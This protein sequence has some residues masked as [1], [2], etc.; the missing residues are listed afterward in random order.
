MRTF[1]IRLLLLPLPLLLASCSPERVPVKIPIVYN[2]TNTVDVTAETLAA[3]RKDPWIQIGARTPLIGLTSV[4]PSGV[5]GLAFYQMD[6]Y[7]FEIGLKESTVIVAINGVPVENI[8]EARKKA[9]ENRARQENV[10]RPYYQYKDLMAYLFV[11][12]KW[13]EFVLTLYVNFP[14][15]ERVGHPYVPKIEDWRINLDEEAASTK[16]KRETG[17][18]VGAP[19][20]LKDC[21]H[22]PELVVIPEGS[23]Y[24]GAQYIE[25][26][27]YIEA[28]RRKVTIGYPLAVGKFEVTQGEWRAVMGSNPSIFKEAGERGPVE[29]VDWGDTQEYLKKLNA[30]TGKN[31]RLLTEAEWEY[32]ARAGT[33]SRF[34]F[35]REITTKDANYDGRKDKPAGSHVG[36]PLAVGSFAPNAWGLH[37]MHGNVYEWVQDCKV[38]GYKDVPA[39]GSPAPDTSPCLRVNRGGAWHS[40]ADA[41]RSAERNPQPGSVKVGSLGFRV[42]R[43]LP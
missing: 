13:N 8:F 41:V 38:F 19:R 18:A 6:P 25:V 26:G 5:V 22:C 37:D 3:I 24:Q 40:D 14:S 11:E 4:H 15:R 2:I 35:G 23:Y 30:T 7:L 29:Y 43:T 42:A 20:A 39:D 33:T 9:H 31:Y 1:M 27:P 32:A 21:D 16:I 12:N 36:R 34:S 28:P 17:A 10:R